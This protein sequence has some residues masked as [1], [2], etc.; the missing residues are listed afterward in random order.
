M[1]INIHNDEGKPVRN[2]F[3]VTSHRINHYDDFIEYLAQAEVRRCVEKEGF[4]PSA[5]Q[6][7]F[8]KKEATRYAVIRRDME[9]AQKLRIRSTTTLLESV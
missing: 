8:F 2:I 3:T 5:E 7:A 1:D 4:T 6:I 9:T